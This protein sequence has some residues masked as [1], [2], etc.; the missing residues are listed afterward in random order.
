VAL[1]SVAI[2]PSRPHRRPCP[3]VPDGRHRGRDDQSR[4]HVL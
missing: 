1:R 2:L 3:R 4:S